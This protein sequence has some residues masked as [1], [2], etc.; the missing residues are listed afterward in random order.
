MSLSARLRAVMSSETP[1]EERRLAGLVADRDLARMQGAHTAGWRHHHLFG[2][3]AHVGGGKDGAID[4]GKSLGHR[5]RKDFCIGPA[6]DR[7]SRETHQ[8]LGRAV[9]SHEAQFLGIL[10]EDH[11]RK[12]IDH[13]IE[14]AF[15]ASQRSFGVFASVEV[16]EDPAQCDE[17]ER[18]RERTAE[19]LGEHQ[20]LAGACRSRCAPSSAAPLHWR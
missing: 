6:E 18:Q 7:A 5:R 10:D 13:R 4:G 15:R 8:L 1:Q 3:V 19:E 16:G 2:D 9:E 20:G 11:D 12:Q 14:E 17:Q